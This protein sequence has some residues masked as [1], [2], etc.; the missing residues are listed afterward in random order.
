MNLRR[1][2]STTTS[3]LV[4]SISKL[5]SVDLS[6]FSLAPCPTHMH[7]NGLHTSGKSGWLASTD[8]GVYRMVYIQ[9]I[10]CHSVMGKLSNL[11]K[12]QWYPMY[13]GNKN[14][15]CLI[16]LLCAS[17]EIK[18][19]L[20]TMHTTHIVLSVNSCW[21]PNP[22]TMHGSPFSEP[23]ILFQVHALSSG[24]MSGKP[25]PFSSPGKIQFT[26]QGAVQMPDLLKL[27][28]DLPIPNHMIAS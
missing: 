11:S 9:I 7:T 18:Q 24:N 10:P 22:G 3:V 28:C 27:S 25:I 17:S 1:C 15:T 20:S 2:L 5:A 13:N 16:W 4:L 12:H 23:A 21:H 19:V 8:S 6:A 26:I 14:R